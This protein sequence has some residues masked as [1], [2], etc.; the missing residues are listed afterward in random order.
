LNKILPFRHSSSLRIIEDDTDGSGIYEF[1][2]V[3]HSNYDLSRTV[4]GIN[5][6]VGRNTQQWKK[7]SDANT[8]RWL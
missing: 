1:L 8:A 7:R 3:I 4:S 2:L 5:G 6:D